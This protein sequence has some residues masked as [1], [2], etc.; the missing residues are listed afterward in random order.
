MVEYAKSAC[1]KENT[2]VILSF[3]R[4]LSSFRRCMSTVRIDFLGVFI[5]ERLSFYWSPTS[6]VSLFQIHTKVLE[7]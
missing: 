5:K 3:V 7:H 2:P 4:R 1:R 6:E